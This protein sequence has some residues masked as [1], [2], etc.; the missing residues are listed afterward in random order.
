MFG[1]LRSRP[2]QFDR[3]TVT[4]AEAN[5]FRLNELKVRVSRADG[6]IR[7]YLAG[8]SQLFPEDRDPAC[9]VLL[10]V[11]VELGTAPAAADEAPVVPGRTTP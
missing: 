7:T 8:Q 4:L 10:E 1:F 11:L 2:I 6:L 5:A 9:D 3:D